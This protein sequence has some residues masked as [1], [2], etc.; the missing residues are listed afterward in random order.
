MTIGVVA[1]ESFELS[2]LVRRLEN[3]RQ[4]G[5]PLRYTCVGQ[6]RGY[7]FICCADGPGQRLAERAAS[8][9][10]DAFPVQGIWSVGL[11]GA[12]EDKLQA[13]D[14]V[15]GREVVDAA[16]GDRFRAEG[17][18]HSVRPNGSD[19]VDAVTIVSQDR[20]AQT[21]EE[22]RRLRDLGC[23]V[24]MESAAVARVAIRKG[25]PFECIKVVSDTAEESFTIDLNRARDRQGRFRPM[26]V[27]R[28]ALRHPLTGIPEIRSLFRR[29]RL[30][31]QRL[32]D[33]IDNSR[34]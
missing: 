28:E 12:L 34:I 26:A 1:A 20:V 5:L 4:I 19:A 30:G 16:S 18:V 32:G 13:G 21:A 14:V 11:C 25:V 31:A 15:T 27:L 2:G 33:W 3:R 22:K 24:D 29:S 8:L 7:E 9:L 17:W 23:V 6:W 10:T